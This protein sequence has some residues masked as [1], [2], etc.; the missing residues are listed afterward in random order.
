MAQGEI[1]VLPAILHVELVPQ[2][3]VYATDVSNSAKMQST[4]EYF[5]WALPQL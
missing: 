2:L 4:A 5:L 1:M 3:I